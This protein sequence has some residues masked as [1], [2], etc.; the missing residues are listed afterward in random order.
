[1]P[2]TDDEGSKAVVDD[3][4]GN[5]VDDEET[6]KDPAGNPIPPWFNRGKL[7]PIPPFSVSHFD[8]TQ[9][10]VVTGC[11]RNKVKQFQRKKDNEQ[12]SEDER[13]EIGENAPRRK[14]V[15]FP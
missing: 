9:R 13:G 14:R 3:S 1:M 15:K 10:K 7:T 8:K 12:L 11:H 6:P 5:F 4:N 2:R